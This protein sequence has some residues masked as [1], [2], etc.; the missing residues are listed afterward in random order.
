MDMEAWFF[1]TLMGIWM[2]ILLIG[3]GVIIGKIHT[4][5][6]QKCNKDDSGNVRKGIDNNSILHS[7]DT[8]M[9]NSDVGDIHGQ[10]DS[11]RNLGEGCYERGRITDGCAARALEIIA[12]EFRKLL[13]Q[14]ELD[15]LQRG[16]EVLK[17]RIGE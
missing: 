6:N 11:G 17:N 5:Y 7:D 12:L 2:A 16:T 4:T 13:T 3:I 8:D 1:A 15:A 9:D 14:T 10:V